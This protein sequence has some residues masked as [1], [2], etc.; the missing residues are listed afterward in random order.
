MIFSED[1]LR[2]IIAGKTVGDFY[3]YRGGT[4]KQ[5]LFF[6][7]E[8]I[9]KFDKSKLLDYDVDFDSYGCGYSSYVDLFLYKK[10]RRSTIVK[11]NSDYIDGISIYISRLAPVAVLG[12]NQ[13][14]KH[15][16][17]GGYGFLSTKSINKLPEGDWKN[18][19]N[20]IKQR[21]EKN[22]ITFLS[23][24][25]VNKKLDF[26]VEIS[27]NLSEDEYKVFDALFHWMD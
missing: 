8:L 10:N 25:I 20:Y 13:K 3:P 15:D 9:Y 19:I 12:V 14:T 5:I 17:G 23:N 4:Q 24:K 22:N 6:I 7:K 21:F 16:S 18:E 27:T 1:E 26:D 2:Q 11:G